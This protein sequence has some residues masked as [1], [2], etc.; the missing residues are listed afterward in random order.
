[1][2][3]KRTVASR[4]QDG[5]RDARAGARVRHRVKTRVLFGIDLGHSRGRIRGADRAVADRARARCSICSARSIGPRREVLIDG[6]TSEPSTTTAAHG[7]AA[8]S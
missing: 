8:R 2:T 7:F 4:R 6:S 1:M 3:A 5:H